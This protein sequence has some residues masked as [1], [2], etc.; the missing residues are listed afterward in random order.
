MTDLDKARDVSGHLHRWLADPDRDLTVYTEDCLER[1]EATIDSLVA[2]VERLRGQ[3]GSAVEVI[4]T[5]DAIN[6]AMSD[7]SVSTMTF[8]ELVDRS[9]AAR[10]AWEK[11]KPNG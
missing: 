4:A 5:H 6:A 2:E 1:A 10:A 11:V 8:G 9:R 7:R 3:V